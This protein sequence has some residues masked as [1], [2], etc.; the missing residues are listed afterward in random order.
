MRQTNFVL[1]TSLSHDV[2]YII[3]T[4]YS[5]SDCHETATFTVISSVTSDTGT[6]VVVFIVITIP[7]IF[8]WV[9]NTLVSLW[10]RKETYS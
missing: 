6:F 1:P 3:S 8:A 10:E 2:F 4:D 5:C 7:A 9:G